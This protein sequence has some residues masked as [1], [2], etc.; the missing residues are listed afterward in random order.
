MKIA[1]DTD[2]VLRKSTKLF[3]CLCVVCQCVCFCVCNWRVLCVEFQC[4]C[5]FL[6]RVMFYVV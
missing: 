3:Q 6:V 2:M 1:V 4:L 5:L